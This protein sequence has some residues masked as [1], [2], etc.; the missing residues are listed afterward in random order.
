MADLAEIRQKHP[1]YSDLSDQALADGLYRK[2]YSDMPREQFDAK[3]GLKPADLPSGMG[4]AAG[5]QETQPTAIQDALKKGVFGAQPYKSYSQWGHEQLEKDK[6]KSLRQLGH[7]GAPAVLGFAG[8]GMA[9]RTPGMPSLRPPKLTGGTARGVEALRQE[10]VAGAAKTAGEETA[11][12]ASQEATAAKAAKAQEQLRSQPAVAAQ[13]AQVQTPTPEGL[14]E[15][16]RVLA[17]LREKTRVLQ[18]SYQQAG[19]DVGQAQRLVAQAGRREQDVE[20]G[21]QKLEQELLARSAMTAD[22]FGGKLRQVTQEIN[23][24][25]TSIRANQSGFK[26]AIESAGDVPRVSTAGARAMIAKNIKEMINPDLQAALSS[27][28]GLL[29]TGGK[30]ARSLRAVESARGYLDRI[31]RSK[32]IGALKIDKE[33]VHV[34]KQVKGALVESAVQSWP[35]YRAAL[36]K[37]RILSRPLDIVERKGALAKVIDADPLSGDYALSEAQVVAHVIAGARA[38]K[39]VFIRMLQESPDLKEPARLAFTQDLF[40]REQVPTSAGLRSWLKNNERPLKQLGLYNE[41]RDIRV[42]RETAAKAVQEAKGA[43]QGSMAELRAAEKAETAAGQEVSKAERL[44]EKQKARIEAA[45]KEAGREGEQRQV[46]SQKRAK[47]SA[48]KLEQRRSQAE[49]EALKRK[50]AADRY[51]QFETEFKALKEAPD[52]VPAL[53]R[54]FVK[55]LADDGKLTPAQYEDMLLKV[56]KVEQTVANRAERVKKIKRL[57]YY[58]VLMGVAGYESHRAIRMIFPH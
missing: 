2:F 6:G 24:K 56:Q 29:E 21:V 48:V 32:E 51:G 35:P 41:F 10:S 13:R 9:A 36:S 30:S 33:T 28:D 23:D 1:E 40:V 26:E 20:M 57:V 25:Y 43:K 42:A 19:M 5:S 46:L 55:R 45:E 49:G 31:I 47:E 8:G 34:I 52:K 50:A 44:R 54:S 18:Q 16:Q 4:A 15:K 53:A 7:E 38:G 27:L 17:D 58:G 39:K 22:E 11:A 3:V 14:A 12:G 37:W